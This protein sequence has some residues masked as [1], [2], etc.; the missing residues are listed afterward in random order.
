MLTSEGQKPEINSSDRCVLVCHNKSCLRSNS[1]EVFETFKAET[2]N[3]DGV[4]IE[5]SGCLGQCST[6]PTVRVTP[7]E[8]WY[9]RVQPEKVPLIV[10]QH[11]QGDKPVDEMLN[12]RIHPRF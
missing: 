3:M 6:G 10:I 7:D 11:L 1:T 12:P 2:E 5:A 8:I 4:K 9:Y